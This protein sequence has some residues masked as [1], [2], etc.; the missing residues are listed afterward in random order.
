MKK[1]IVLLLFCA[2]SMFASAQIDNN[3]FSDINSDGLTGNPTKRNVNPDSL[4]TDKEIPK[5]IKVWSVDKRFGDIVKATPDTLSH[6]FMNS[7]FTTGM[8]GEFNTTGNLGAPRINRIFI[9]R[10]QEGNFIFTNPY[11]Y[12]VTDVEKFHFT[13][14]LSPFTNLSFNTCGDRQTGEDH[15][16]AK[17][18]VNAGK[19]IGLGFKF[20][21]IYGR[22]YY[23]D[24]STSHFNYTMYGSYLGDRYQAHVLMSTNHQKVTENGGITNDDYIVHRTLPRELRYI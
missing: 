18:G 21:Y 13:N 4:G 8:R 7:I 9:D 24:Q 22:G 19:R 3:Q 14:T 16:T 2:V 6:M 11:D 20:D 23:S 12:F 17:F 1:R 5:G 15:F 10:D